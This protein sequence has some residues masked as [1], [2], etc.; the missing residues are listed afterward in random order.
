MSKNPTIVGVLAKKPTTKATK[1]PKQEAK[2][3][4]AAPNADA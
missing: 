2:K 4:E 1:A 3:E